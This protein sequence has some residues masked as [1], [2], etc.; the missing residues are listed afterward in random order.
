MVRDNTSQ[1]TMEF[2]DVMEKKSGC[3]FHCDYCVCQNKVYSFGDRIHNSHDSVMSGEL[4][5]F[6]YKIN[7]EHILLYIWNGE[8]LKLTNWKVSPGF[9][10]ETEITGTYILANVLRHLEPPVVLGH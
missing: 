5:K 1:E 6:N 7:I 2:P 9:H 4:W 3:F 10:L 8:Q